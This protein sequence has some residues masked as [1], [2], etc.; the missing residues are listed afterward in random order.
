M[1]EK[2]EELSAR[3]RAHIRNGQIAQYAADL[4][5]IAGLFGQEKQLRNQL[6]MLF[7]AFYIDLSGLGRAP[8][9]DRAVAERICAAAVGAEMKRDELERFFFEVIP[10]DMVAQHPFSVR[11]CWYLANLCLDDKADQADYI[12]TKV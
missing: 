11:D 2:L 10:S 9:I 12:L 5:E 6:K 4:K 8:Y 7:L 3:C 1:E